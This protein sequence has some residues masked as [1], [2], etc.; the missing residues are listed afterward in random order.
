MMTIN[1]SLGFIEVSGKQD[2]NFN[3]EYYI[4]IPMK[5]VTG[6]TKQKLFTTNKE[7]EIDEHQEDEIIYKNSSKKIKYVNLKISGNSENYKVSLARS[8]HIAKE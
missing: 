6:I 7:Y 5:L 3:M 2:M 4:K 1:S 8:K